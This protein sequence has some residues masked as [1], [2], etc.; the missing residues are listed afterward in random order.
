MK[1]FAVDL[2][3]LLTVAA[4]VLDANG[5][6]LEAN[7]GFVR[8]LPGDCTQPI[9]ARVGRFFVRPAFSAL[10]AAAIQ[11]GDCAYRG[12]MTIGDQA[13]ETRT[14]RGQVWRT[15][16]GIRVLAEYDIAD[17]ER[18]NDAMLE[19]NRE[20]AISRDTLART[21][22]ALKQREAQIVEASLTDALTGV[23]NRRRL[24]QALAVEIGRVRRMGGTLSAI[25][26]DVDHFKR[27]NDEHGH[28]AGDKVLARVAALLK[29]QTR[30]T[31]TVARF[32]GEEFIVLM[33]HT[34]IAQAA[35]KAEQFRG[36][37]AA[38]VIAPMTAP[39]TSS[40]GVAEL[41]CDEDGESLLRRADAALYRAKQGGRNRV[42][43]AGEPSNRAAN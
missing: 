5:V 1:S 6:L 43:A 42:V 25:M 36:A 17:L 40:F 22:V 8:L 28:G 19:L 41:E 27:I 23:G 24:E 10:I 9:G 29:S 14:L 3:S 35:A 2:D 12:A 20:S 16:N 21:N 31:D 18:L 13:G 4:A 15:G 37:L 32:G 39:V 34:G 26:A 7:A 38:E 33:P 30:A 11:E